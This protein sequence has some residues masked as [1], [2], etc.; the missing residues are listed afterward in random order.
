M[1]LSQNEGPDLKVLSNQI[2]HIFYNVK[3]TKHVIFK[4]SCV[5]TIQFLEFQKI[6]F[7]LFLRFKLGHYFYSL[8][9]VLFDSSASLLPMR[10]IHRGA[11]R[12]P[13]SRGNWFIIILTCELWTRVS[14]SMG[15]DRLVLKLTQPFVGLAFH[16]KASEKLPT[17]MLSQDQI[18]AQLL[19]VN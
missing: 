4:A 18:S 14:F 12:F 19:S 9:L 2:R 15:S 17:S 5:D 6:H 13:N 3:G 10:H 8:W 7:E 11:D 16:F 1:L